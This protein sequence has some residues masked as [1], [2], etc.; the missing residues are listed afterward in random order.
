M[1]F[2]CT[3]LSLWVFVVPADWCA[4]LGC[5]TVI[6]QEEVVCP[7]VRLRQLY[8]PLKP[9]HLTQREVCAFK[10]FLFKRTNMIT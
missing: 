5:E 8:I 7:S 10:L 3:F 9:V 6:K 2:N 1:I 4:P